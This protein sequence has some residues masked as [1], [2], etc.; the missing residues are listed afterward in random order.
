VNPFTSKIANAAFS[1]FQTNIGN[2]ETTP[3]KT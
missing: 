3:P 1:F 2:S